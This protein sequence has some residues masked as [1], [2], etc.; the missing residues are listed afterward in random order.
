MKIVVDTNILFSALLK[1][2]NIYAETI[3]LSEN[4]FYSPKF[5][6]VELFKYKEKIIKYAKLPENDVL[7]LLY[8]LLK[9]IRMMEEDQISTYNLQQA[10][11]L[12][13]G[14]DLK[15]IPFVALTL[16]LDGKLW[17]KDDTLK[18]GLIKKGFNNFYSLQNK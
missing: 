6:F 1:T 4:S 11:N 10:Y 18:K 14:V 13:E 5:V 15:D 3:L 7:E 8:R 9:S 16:D 12:C 2:P 17:T